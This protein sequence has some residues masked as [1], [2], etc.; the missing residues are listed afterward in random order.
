MKYCLMVFITALLL[1][2]PTEGQRRP[3]SN[4]K[5]ATRVDS[6]SAP[7]RM[8]GNTGKYDTVLHPRRRSKHATGTDYRYEID[9]DTISASPRAK[10]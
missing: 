10:P 4:S 1:S 6:I 2:T 5:R 7:P 8:D 3:R 9:K